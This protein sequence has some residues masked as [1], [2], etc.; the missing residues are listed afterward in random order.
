MN[1]CSANGDMQEPA[2]EDVNWII[3]WSS[4]LID[5]VGYICWSY[6]SLCTH[7]VLPSITLYIFYC[8]GRYWCSWFASWLSQEYSSFDSKSKHIQSM[9]YCYRLQLV[10]AMLLLCTVS[11]DVKLVCRWTQSL[12]REGSMVYKCSCVNNELSV[13]FWLTFWLNPNSF[14]IIMI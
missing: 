1:R 4:W 13:T 12:I 3:Q 7:T 9:L 6:T 11:K 5:W 14:S 8:I 10:L 2:R